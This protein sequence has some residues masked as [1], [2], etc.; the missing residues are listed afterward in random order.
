GYPKPA[1]QIT[2]KCGAVECGGVGILHQ[3]GVGVGDAGRAYTHISGSL[4]YSLTQCLHEQ[5][6]PPQDMSIP[7][8]R[9]RR[10]PLTR[11]HRPGSLRPQDHPFC[12]GAPQIN[13]PKCFH[14]PALSGKSN[15]L[16][17]SDP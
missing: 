6:Y 8:G 4:A 14:T 2:A 5:F 10:N 17:D 9:L 13:A 12:L 16:T 7:T 11:Q 1:L 15:T 3:T